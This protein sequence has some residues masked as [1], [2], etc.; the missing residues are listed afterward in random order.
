MEEILFMHFGWRVWQRWG[1]LL[2]VSLLFFSLTSSKNYRLVLCFYFVNFSSYS[3]DFLLLFLTLL[4]KF[5]LFLILSFNPKVS[6]IIFS[7]LILILLIY[8]YFFSYPFYRIVIGF[9]FTFQ[10]KF[11]VYYFLQFNPNCFDFLILL[12]NLLFFSI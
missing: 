12:L 6:Q 5:Y 8:F 3:F 4:K 10:S 2:P 11:M 9:Q 7:N 1:G